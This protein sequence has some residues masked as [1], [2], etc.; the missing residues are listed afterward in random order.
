MMCGSVGLECGM[1]MY[2]IGWRGLL[3][4]VVGTT[5]GFLV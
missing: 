3:I 1:M 5:S 4:R 2:D